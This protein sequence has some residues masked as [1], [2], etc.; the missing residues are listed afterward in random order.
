M[1]KDAY[2][3]SHDYSARNDERILELRAH[4][5][6]EG[7]GVF[8]MLVE[9]LAESG[10]KLNNNLLSG[11]ALQFGVSKE[12]LEKILDKCI[13]LELLK[14]DGNTIYSERLLRHFEFRKERSESG[15]IGASKK[16]HSHSAAI[17]EPMAKNGKGKESKEKEIIENNNKPIPLADPIREFLLNLKDEV[18][19]KEVK[20][21]HPHDLTIKLYR[22]VKKKLIHDINGVHKFTAAHEAYR[23][24]MADEWAKSTGNASIYFLFDTVND[25]NKADERLMQYH[26]KAR[27]NPI[28]DEEILC[29]PKMMLA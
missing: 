6:A 21:Q 27:D 23:A 3:F 2:Y 11:K 13:E 25:G 16:W 26:R 15:K 24:L 4:C 20:S 14:C 1:A 5:G 29:G 19:T 12:T 18:I 7:Y 22:I 8:W 28:E 10:G 17:Y 9:M